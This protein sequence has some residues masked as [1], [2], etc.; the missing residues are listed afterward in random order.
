MEFDV[1]VKFLPS[2]MSD[3]DQLTRGKGEGG[4]GGGVGGARARRAAGAGAGTGAGAGV[5]VLLLFFFPSLSANVAD[6]NERREKISNLANFI[7]P[8]GY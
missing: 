7:M 3:G 8:Q 5:D 4:G 2:A 1:D 6:G